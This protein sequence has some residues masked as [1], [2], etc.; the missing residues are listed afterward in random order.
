MQRIAIRHN[1]AVLGTV[2][3]PKQRGKDKYFGRDALFGSS[4]LARKVETVVLLELHNADDPNSVRRCT[5]LPRNGRAERLYFEWQHNGL[6]LTAEPQ[7]VTEETALTRMERSVF[8]KYKPGDVVM[9]SPELGPEATFYRWRKQ[10]AKDGKLACSSGCYY[11]PHA[12]HSK[13]N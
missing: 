13:P 4:A 2:G 11:V 5:V 7:A 10:A 8:A 9:Y 1:V 3:S 6:V 12:D